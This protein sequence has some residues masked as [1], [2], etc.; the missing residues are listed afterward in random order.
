MNAANYG[1]KTERQSTRFTT[2]D[3]AF[4]RMPTGVGHQVLVAI[5]SMP[6]TVDELMQ[7]LELSHST[8]SAAVNKLMREGYVEDGGTRRLTRSGRKAIVW[9]RTLIAT[10]R[11]SEMPTRRQLAERIERALEWIKRRPPT[12]ELWVIAGMLNGDET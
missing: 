3:D 4:R 10:D 1:R 2:S 5:S 8:C 11:S 6:R 12:N 9:V 7:D